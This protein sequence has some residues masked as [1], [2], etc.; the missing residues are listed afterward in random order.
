MNIKWECY[1]SPM[2]KKKLR[3]DDEP[4]SMPVILRVLGKKLEGD[5]RQVLARHPDKFY[6]VYLSQIHILSKN[7]KFAYFWLKY[8]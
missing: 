3:G 6:D 5:F 2:K 1:V 7:K 4:V 8:Q